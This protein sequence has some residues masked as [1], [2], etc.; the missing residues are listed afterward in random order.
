MSARSVKTERRLI[1]EMHTA[2]LGQRPCDVSQRI[3]LALGDIRSG[4]Q[5][6]AG[7][8]A[9][10]QTLLGESQ[11]HRLACELDGSPVSGVDNAGHCLGA[12]ALGHADAE[13]DL[14]GAHFTWLA[15]LLCWSDSLLV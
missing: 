13:A 4:Q 2:P 10:S 5:R 9:S 12:L 1:L 15:T 3:L 11:A 14:T 8:C 7:G 6:L